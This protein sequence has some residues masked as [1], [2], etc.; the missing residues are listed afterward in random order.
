MSLLNS[1]LAR[2]CGAFLRT[3]AL[4]LAI[5]GG[6]VILACPGAIAWQGWHL[7]RHADAAPPSLV[8]FL[9]WIEIGSLAAPARGQDGEAVAWLLG[10]PLSLAAL[11]LGGAALACAYLIACAGFEI[12]GPPRN[13]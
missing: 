10:C 8:D 2:A 9:R 13:D 6:W 4:G 5:C 3:V 1:A 11:I 7:L 12:Q